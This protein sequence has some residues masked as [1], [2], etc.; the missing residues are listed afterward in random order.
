MVDWR[1]FGFGDAVRDEFTRG[2]PQGT[3]NI[4]IFPFA[5]ELLVSGE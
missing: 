5:G 4:N 2:I 3:N 1:D